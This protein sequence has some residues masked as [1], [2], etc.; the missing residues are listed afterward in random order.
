MYI[1][2]KLLT[3]INPV[4]KTINDQDFEHLCNR[5]GIEVES[6]NRHHKMENLQIAYLEEVSKHPNAEKLSVAQV[7]LSKDKIVTVVCGA[8]NIKAKVYAIYAPIGTKFL[9]GRIIDSKNIRGVDS[10]GMLCGYSELTTLGCEMLSS[11]DADGII[12]LDEAKLGDTHI[13]NYIDNDDTIYDLSI[14]SNRNDLNAAVLLAHELVV[15]LKLE[16][17]LP[18]QVTQI[19]QATKI[20]VIDKKLSSAF[21][22]IYI[23]QVQSFKP[24]WKEKQLLMSCGYKVHENLLDLMNIFTIRYGNPI[25]VYNADQLKP[26]NIN[27]KQLTAE[28]TAIGL[29]NQSYKLPKNTIGIFHKDQLVNIAGIIGLNESKYLDNCR[30]VII[31]VANFTPKLIKQ[32]AQAT[33]IQTKAQAFF[34]KEYSA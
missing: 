5:L 33:K 21:G 19:K 11:E 7:R 15:G 30:S 20:P 12:L 16:S 32:T 24:N 29:D 2:K 31:E 13:E 1:S 34:C 25:H 14:P 3:E 22:L 27:V 26:E 6:T 4:F 17:N 18:Q 9:D 8:A 28:T 23:P 10:F